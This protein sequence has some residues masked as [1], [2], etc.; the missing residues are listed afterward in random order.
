MNLSTR[1]LRA[2]VAAAAHQNFTRAAAEVCLSQ[3]AFSAL[4]KSLEIELGAQLFVRNTR[5]VELT[6]FGRLFEAFA[7]RSLFETDTAM[8][9]LQDY[10]SGRVGR[11]SVAAI[12][13]IAANWLPAVLAN[14]RT[15]FPGVTVG[16][17]DGMSQECVAL[18]THGEIDFALATAGHA[19]PELARES[20]WT[21]RF[22]LVCAAGHPLAKKRTVGLD[23]VLPW[24]FIAFVPFSSVRQCVDAAFGS[25]VPNIVM[26]L[27]H[28]ATVSAMVGQGIGVTIV[29]SLTLGQFDRPDVAIRPLCDPGLARE[30]VILRRRNREPS[31]PA[32]ALHRLIVEHVAGLSSRRPRTQ[33]G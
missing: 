2:F 12:P 16:V 22:H 21:D 29:P 26:E 10:V 7:R 33:R 27:E 13:S 6:S 23:D 11:V 24:P 14:F 15:A 1:Q 25:R 28:L 18:L 20:L 4:I 8:K 17:R 19:A 5:N 9:D 30:I 31:L 3:P 32:K